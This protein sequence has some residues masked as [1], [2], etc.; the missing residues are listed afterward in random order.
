MAS[1]LRNLRSSSTYLKVTSSPH[2]A[3]F[4]RAFVVDWAVVLILLPQISKYIEHLQPFQV[5]R[6]VK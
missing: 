2:L 1:A 4:A 5:S 3:W 6:V